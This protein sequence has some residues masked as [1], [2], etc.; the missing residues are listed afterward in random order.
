MDISSIRFYFAASVLLILII[1]GLLGAQV[2]GNLFWW[3]QGIENVESLASIEDQDGDGWPEA[4]VMTYDAGAPQEDDLYVIKGNSSGYGNIIWSSK[5]YGGLS[6]GGGYGDQCLSTI[7]DISNDGLTDI[8]L[9][10]AWG[11]RTAFGID[12]N[13]G[14]ILFH[15]DSYDHPPDGWCYAVNPIE[16]LNEDGLDEAL[17]SFGNY[18]QAAFCLDGASDGDATVIWKWN[19]DNDGVLSICSLGDVNSDGYADALA[20]CGGNFYDTRVVLIDGSSIGD[21]AQSLWEYETDSGLQDVTAIA[22]VNGSGVDDALSGGWDYFVRCIEG[23]STGTGELIWQR[24][25]GT[26]IMRV[27]AIPDV[28]SDGIEDVLVGSWDNAIICLSGANGGWIWNTPTGTLNGGDVWTIYPIPD[29]DG[30]GVWDVLAGSFDTKIYCVSGA[31]GDVVWTY[32]T[33]N[34]LYTVRYIP[35]VNGDGIADALG[36]TQMI[37]SSGG[38]VYCIEGDSQGPWMDISVDPDTTVIR[39]GRIMGAESGVLR[40]HS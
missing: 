2:N 39:A 19:A 29:I 20:G 24:N 36:G 16:D 12:G 1:P 40:F 22:D 11:G 9:G 5:P 33:G 6:G 27:E 25:I 10:T 14:D 4:V 31:T 38:R 34:R 37:S 32:T 7:S 21:P 23:G 8:L 3:F 13:N 18:T 26:V 35:D 17:A 28:N 15:Y 30:D